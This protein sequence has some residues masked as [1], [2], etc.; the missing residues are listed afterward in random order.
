MEFVYFAMTFKRV[1]PSNLST[2]HNVTFTE[3]TVKQKS[4]HH[5]RSGLIKNSKI[6]SLNHC[7]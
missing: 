6:D 5:I 1:F 3:V 2:K 4:A 7:Y